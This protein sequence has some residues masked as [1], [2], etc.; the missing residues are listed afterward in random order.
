MPGPGGGGGG[1]FGGGS[2]GGGFGGG[3]FGGGFGGGHHGHHGHHHHHYYG[4]RFGGWF[5]GPRYYGYGGGCLGGLLGMIFVPVIMI[6]VIIFMLI[7][8]FGSALGNVASGGQVIYDESVMQEYAD[9][10]YYEVFG[11]YENY[12][13]NLLVVFLTNEEY[14]GYYAI[15]WAGYNLDP[16]IY[17]LFGDERAAFSQMMLSTVNDTY[18]KNSLSK[19]L[20]MTMDKLATKIESFGLSD[21]FDKNLVYNGEMPESRL[22]NYSALAMSE[23]LVNDALRDF[24]DRTGIPAVIVVDEMEEAIGKKLLAQD[25]FLVVILIGLV[26]LVIFM[27]VKAIKEKKKYGGQGGDSSNNGNNNNGNSNN[28]NYGFYEDG[29]RW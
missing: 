1:G 8:S 4:P 15:A 22:V 27:I 2:R 13:N 28:S 16:K 18:Y 7:G 23:E 17:N 25:I 3:G 24:T 11:E 10:R 9:D 12:D 26:A 5:F 6:F 29:R 20:E 21:S 14:D 19:D